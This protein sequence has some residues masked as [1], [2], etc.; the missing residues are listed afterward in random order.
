MLSRHEPAPG[1]LA[2]AAHAMPAH[3]RRLAEDVLADPSRNRARS[4]ESLLE[5]ERLSPAAAGSQ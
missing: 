4:A 1:A 3:L 2:L 5:I